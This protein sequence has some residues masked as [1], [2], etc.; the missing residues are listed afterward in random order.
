MK[1]KRMALIFVACLLTGTTYGQD[2]TPFRVKGKSGFKDAKGNVVIEAKF[3]MV[4]NFSEGL[5]AVSPK[6][7][8]KW[9]Y[10]DQTGEIVIPVKY[11]LAGPFSNGLAKVILKKKF[12]FIDKTGKQV[13]T[14]K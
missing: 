13:D 1:V 9:G 6:M 2:L 4:N 14:E 11:K 12:I 7:G 3:G 10:I 8:G 5:A